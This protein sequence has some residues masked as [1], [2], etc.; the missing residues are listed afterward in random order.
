[1]QGRNEEGVKIVTA[2]G[3]IGASKPFDAIADARRKRLGGILLA[4][5][6]PPAISKRSTHDLVT[7]AI[8]LQLD[9]NRPVLKT[10]ALW[11][12]S[13]KQLS[14]K[15]SGVPVMTDAA[16]SSNLA[17]TILLLHN[18][19][20]NSTQINTQKLLSISPM[21]RNAIGEEVQMFLSA[22]TSSDNTL[23]FSSWPLRP[24]TSFLALP[25]ALG[26][27]ESFLLPTSPH[28]ALGRPFFIDWV[29]EQ[30]PRLTLVTCNS[31]RVENRQA[32]IKPGICAWEREPCVLL[33]VS[34]IVIFDAALVAILTNHH[35]PRRQSIRKTALPGPTAAQ[36]PIALSLATISPNLSA[37]ALCN[38]IA[39]HLTHRSC[40]STRLRSDGRES[41]LNGTTSAVPTAARKSQ[42]SDGMQSKVVLGPHG[43]LRD[44]IAMN[45]RK[46][47]SPGTREAPTAANLYPAKPK[48]SARAAQIYLCR[49]NPFQHP[50]AWH[51]RHHFHSG[52][53][54]SQRLSYLAA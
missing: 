36:H 8:A 29:C 12:D 15:A 50:R 47:H 28:S 38:A 11:Q 22:N 9:N 33:A 21:N 27:F 6:S 1:M 43:R 49:P 52:L 19:H 42:V 23:A 10:S 39:I 32:Y 14:N 44:M 24:Y 46:N 54:N 35:N 53:P 20:L 34:V 17:H 37:N 41:I 2:P 40:P 48:Q 3:S 4:S 26:L 7:A 16:G 51:P 30:T 31:F 25:A 13:H 18:G 5:I 45:I